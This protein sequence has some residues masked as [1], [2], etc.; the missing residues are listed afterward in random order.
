VGASETPDT[1]GGVRELVDTEDLNRISE[2]REE[3][4]K[5]FLRI[6]ENAA[7]LKKFCNQFDFNHGLGVS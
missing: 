4:L 3:A 6:S 2:L 5:I 1:R 7:C